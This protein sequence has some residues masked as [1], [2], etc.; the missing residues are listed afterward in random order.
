MVY[1]KS[2]CTSFCLLSSMSSLHAGTFRSL[3]TEVIS[4]SPTITTTVQPY[5]VELATTNP[6]KKSKDTELLSEVY[7]QILNSTNDERTLLTSSFSF[8]DH[9]KANIN[10]ILNKLRSDIHNGSKEFEE[11]RNN[12]GHFFEE[13]GSNIEYIISRAS[14][15][16]NRL[17]Y[18]MD[19]FVNY[20]SPKVLDHTKELVHEGISLFGG[21]GDV[22]KVGHETVP[23]IETI[24]KEIGGAVDGTKSELS[25]IK[26]QTEEIACD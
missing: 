1:L 9:V 25:D 24:T 5:S 22:S 10:S 11:F 17:G 12:T 20:T 14:Y 16:M 8:W 6:I 15:F 7:S 2:I 26:S 13:A 4:E 19:N 21:V 18:N 3:V 23:V